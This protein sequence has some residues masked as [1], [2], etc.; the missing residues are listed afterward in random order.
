MNTT[1]TTKMPYGRYEG[2]FIHSI[3]DRQYLQWFYNTMKNLNPIVK[4]ALRY[5]LNIK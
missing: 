5:K 2:Q 4:S 3:N 1:K